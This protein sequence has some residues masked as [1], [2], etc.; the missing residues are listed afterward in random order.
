M[1]EPLVVAWSS[2]KDSAL[3]LQK[4]L[5]TDIY[6]VTL[7]TTV[8]E[9][10]ER[11]S[12]HGVRE[13]LLHVQAESLGLP[14]DIVTIPK[15]CSD[16]EYRR[17]MESAMLRHHTGGARSVV[18]GDI[19]LEGIREYREENLARI[20]MKPVFPLWQVDTRE[21]SR[22]FIDAGFQAVITCVDTQALPPSFTGRL[23]DQSLVADLPAEADPCG[24]RGEFHSF[25]FDGPIFSKPV[26]FR[27]G[28]VVLRDDRFSFCD[29]FPLDGKSS[30]EK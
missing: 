1:K 22:T 20:G 18:F 30:K 9:D 4:I 26:E 14:I 2:G 12:M 19:F 15:R 13:Q 10:Y 23:Y 16:E 27:R 3:A 28:E 25:V 6:Q 24:E 29:L 8:T 17:R 7:L 21:L 5:E 11:I